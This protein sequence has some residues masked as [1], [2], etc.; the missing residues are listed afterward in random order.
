MVKFASV[1]LNRFHAAGIIIVASV[2]V[3]LVFGT[4]LVGRAFSYPAG[5]VCEK[6]CTDH[7]AIICPSDSANTAVSP[8]GNGWTLDSTGKA[9]IAANAYAYD[10]AYMG[11]C[12]LDCSK[13]C[14][15]PTGPKYNEFVKEKVLQIAVA[16]EYEKKNNVFCYYNTPVLENTC[17]T[18]GLNMLTQ[19]HQTPAK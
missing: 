11:G 19:A 9:W 3:S 4:G 10:S 13:K 5:A 16:R 15:I 2:I 8:A 7:Y 1:E 12:S 18:I 6:S 17:A 14:E